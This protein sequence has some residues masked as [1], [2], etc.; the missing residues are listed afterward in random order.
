LLHDGP[1]SQLAKS[2]RFVEAYNSF[3]W[4]FLKEIPM[5]ET[6]PTDFPKVVAFR[7]S[8]KL[9]DEDYRSFV[10]AVEAAIAREGKI[11]LFAQFEDFH[12][13]DVKAAWDDFKFGLK[14]FGDFDRIAMVGDRKWEQWMAK[15]CKPFT[16]AKVRYFDASEADAA[17]N[18]VREPEP[19]TVAC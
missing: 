18:W 7:L 2:S 11:R 19:A 1:E 3:G 15:L 8:G 4:R 9:H 12:G 13:W 16:R 14:H 17:W 10:P 5:I 6:L